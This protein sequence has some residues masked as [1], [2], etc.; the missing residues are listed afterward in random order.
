MAQSIQS[1]D[2]KIA[3]VFQG[4]YM[5]PDYQREYVW[6]PEQVEQLLSDIYTEFSDGANGKPP[7]YFIGSIVV[8][9]GKEGVLDLIDGQQRMTT[10]F[11]ALCAIRDRFETIGQSPPGPLSSQI[12]AT[13]ADDEGQDVFRY[14]LELQYEDSGDV[15]V[16]IA[17]KTFDGLGAKP[18][19]SMQNM[20]NAYDSIVTYLTQ[21]FGED[22]K[23]LRAFYGYFTNK[24]KLIRI[25]TED[26]A[27]ALKIF[28]TINDRG[29]GLDSTDLL[30]NL[31]FMKSK[32]AEFDALKIRW[33]ELQDTIYKASE[34]PLRFLRYFIFSEYNVE[35]LRE[36]EIYGWFSKNEKICGYASNSLGFTQKLVDAAKCY[37]NFFKG[38]NADGEERPAL[39]SLKL[40]AGNAT[41]QYLVMLLAGR[42]LESRLFDRLVNEVESLLF[43]YVIT[44]ENMRDFERNFAQWAPEVRKITTEQEL[45]DFLE[46]KMMRSKA[47]LNI[48]FHEAI[49]RLN[50]IDLQVYRLRYVLAKLNQHFEINAFGETEGTRWLKNYIANEYEIEH[51]HPQNPSPEAAQEFGEMTDPSMTNRLGN[52]VLVE[53]QINASLGNKAY[54]EKK[55]VY[56]KSK[57]LFVH[58]ITAVPQIG[59]ATSIDRAVRNVVPYSSWNDQA[60]V[61]RQNMIA[62]LSQ[63]IWNIPGTNTSASSIPS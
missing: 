62:G 11:L 51:I 28:E 19:R 1:Q 2:I 13:A 34:K 50:A 35:K 7:E 25:E 30:K 6:Q 8:C 12:A 61:S 44:R 42:H 23:A 58:S 32:E 20:A 45:D 27:K 22:D 36:D 18:T 17:K 24:V 26:V 16:D 53:K 29:V 5:V 57:L 31:L 39:Q 33:K 54:S 21:Q 38:R 4:F 47:A 10:L 41:R 49:K 55:Q 3:D 40:L 59:K 52:L 14:R 63:E 46:T 15:L 9:E 48:R 60:I 56:P 43:V 37:A